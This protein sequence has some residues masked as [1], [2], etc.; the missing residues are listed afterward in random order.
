MSD[1]QLVRICKSF[2]NGLLGKS[3]SYRMCAA[4]TWPLLGLLEA[5]GVH[6]ELKEVIFDGDELIGNHV[7]MVLD[8]G[9]V[10]DAT[11]DQFSVPQRV[12]PPVYI[13]PPLDIHGRKVGQGGRL[14]AAEGETKHE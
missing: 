11:A 3:P 4:V 9:R 2:R 6:A 7:F 13:G 1:K 10:L 12:L 14:T 8:D 5:F